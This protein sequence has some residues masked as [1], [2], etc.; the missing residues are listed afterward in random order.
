MRHRPIISNAAA[1]S[2]VLERRRQHLERRASDRERG[3]QATSFDLAEASAL[4]AGIEALAW[5]SQESTDTRGV[6]PL[7]LLAQL[8]DT[9]PRDSAAVA[10][11]QDETAELMRGLD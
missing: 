9:D 3:G 8:L 4:T 7:G 6:T 10:R 5:Y 11:L 2:D 1:K